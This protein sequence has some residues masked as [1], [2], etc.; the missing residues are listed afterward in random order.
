MSSARL[1]KEKSGKFFPPIFHR[2]SCEHQGKGFWLVKKKHRGQIKGV[3]SPAQCCCPF[4]HNYL[5]TTMCT[6]LCSFNCSVLALC[7]LLIPTILCGQSTDTVRHEQSI[8]SVTTKIRLTATGRV[9]VKPIPVEN[10]HQFMTQIERGFLVGR[11]LDND[12]LNGQF[13]VGYGAKV[14]F[15][16]WGVG[17]EGDV[18]KEHSN[19]DSLGVA[20]SMVAVGSMVQGGY[21]LL[22]TPHFEVSPLLGI[23][24]LLTSFDI[25]M[26]NPESF[27]DMFEPEARSWSF[28]NLQVQTTLGLEVLYG[29]RVMEDETGKSDLVFGLKGEYSY[30][31]TDQWS[32]GG[33]TIA[34]SEGPDFKLNG[35]G[36]WLSVGWRTEIK[37]KGTP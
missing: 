30:G 21:Q 3:K 24:F 7:S 15:G 6:L 37:G 12:L 14:E 2:R 35:F 5:A 17:I 13:G 25:V 34:L 19:S 11:R 28:D 20:A 8:D 29:I 31:I 10:L 18:F 9:G 26:G 27:A 36:L 22:S 23:G 32:T 16:R 33:Q 4:L 1:L